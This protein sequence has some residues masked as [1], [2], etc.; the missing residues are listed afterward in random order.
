MSER[1]VRP[2]RWLFWV[3]ALVSAGLLGALVARMVQKDGVELLLERLAGLHA[4]WLALAVALH[5][6]AVFAGVSR[7]RLLLDGAGLR[8][9][10]PRLLRSFLVGRFVGAFT[11]STTGL[12][13]W[14]LYDVGRESGAM[15]R[16]AA[17][18][19]IE[20]LVGLVGMAV[21]CAGLIPF[22]GIDAMG[23]TAPVMAAAMALGAALGLYGIRRPAWLG[24][25]VRRVPWARAR[26]A[27]ERVVEALGAS[28]LDGRRAGGAIALGIGSHLAL[29]AV[30]F[31]TARAI[32][33]DAS[34]ATLLVTGNAITLAVLLPVSVGGVGVREGVAVVLL[35]GV[36]VAST[37]AVLVALLGYLTG[38]V[39]ALLGGVLTLAGRRGEVPSA[40]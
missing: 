11:P 7:W 40:A 37:D 22:G 29:S 24:A 14:R 19:A 34:A 3:K 20:K 9:G 12:D 6:A 39:P 10:Y 2:R 13:G 23:P 8:L 33:V 35:A 16:S 36:G 26:A 25:I 15:A 5:F 21:V 4:G 18:I 17:V 38:Q 1:T 32:G 30:F 27:G 28:G 31:A